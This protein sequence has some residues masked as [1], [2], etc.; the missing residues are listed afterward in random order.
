MP[1]DECKDND[2]G[3]SGGGHDKVVEICGD[4]IEKLVGDLTN[5]NQ[6]DICTFMEMSAL[7]LSFLFKQM[8]MVDEAE[9]D[10]EKIYMMNAHQLQTIMTKLTKRAM[11]IYEDNLTDS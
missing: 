7:S 1:F 2:F 3:G 5:H 4:A 8:K 6:C 10:G 11:V 9:V